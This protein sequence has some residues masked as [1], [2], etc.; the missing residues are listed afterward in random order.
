[1]GISKKLINSVL[2]VT[3]CA[4]SNALAQWTT[5]SGNVG[6]YYLG[7]NVGIGTSTP[8]LGY[9]LDVSGGD[10]IINGIT[11]GLGGVG[12]GSTAIGQN[13]LHSDGGIGNTALGFQ[14][15]Q[16]NTSGNYSTA[17]GYLAL[18]AS[19]GGYN[20]AFGA[21][22]LQ[23]NTTGVQNVS[24]G[25]SNLVSNT[26]GNG[27]TGIG[28]NALS[29]NTTGS[30]NSGLGDFAA[31]SNTTGTYNVG[32]GTYALKNNSITNGNTVVGSNA[33]FDFN[34][35]TDTVGYNTVIGYNSG[36]GLTDGNNNTIIGA[37]V[38]GLSSSLSNNI[39]IADGAGNRR[40][41][42][43]ANGNIGIGTTT[44]GSKLDVVGTIRTDVICD[45]TGSNCKTLAAGWPAS[46]T[47]TNIT[48]GIGLT[49]GSITTAGTI[50]LSNTG[51]VAG[52][53]GSATQSAVLAVDAQG[54]VTSASNVAIAG[55]GSGGTAGGDLSGT[56]PNPILV[57][58]GVI[59]GAYTKVNVDTKGRVTS[60]SNL[61]I[62]D[63]KSV[64]TGNWLTASGSCVSGQQLTYSAVSDNLS[65]QAYALTATQVTDA[66]GYVPSSGGTNVS[67]VAS[68]TSPTTVTASND[69]LT[70]NANAG[71]FTVTLPAASGN[72]GKNF[73]FKKIDSSANTVT[74]AAASG[75]TIDGNPSKIM[76][77]QND[78]LKIVSDGTNWLDI[79]Q[80]KNRPTN[81]VR[82]SSGSGTYTP[83]SGVLY[84]KVRMAGGGGGGGGSGTGSTYGSNGTSSTFGST[85][86]VANAGSG[87]AAPAGNGGSG[88][89]TTISSGA[90][91]SGFTGGNG[92]PSGYTADTSGGSGAASFFGGAGGG[93]YRG[94]AGLSAA[95]GT[96]SG[97][98]GGGGSPSVASSSG[99]GA[100]GY[101][102]AQIN[103]LAASYTYSVG[104]GGGGGTAGTSGYAGGSGGSGVIIVEE[105]Y[106]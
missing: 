78:I 51:V 44:P 17:S 92:S 50:G 15:L 84:I 38:T 94:T 34:R 64:G 16:L 60:G 11:V 81:I 49:G 80:K 18:T 90:I 66:L 24:V 83:S 31:Q 77:V 23:N 47:V 93:G 61:T 55:A 70:L 74:I 98:G 40:I 99:G 89:S 73:T 52:T 30:Y 22:A 59:A 14:A 63:V 35:T 86:L 2:L 43:D 1:M 105:Y 88:G 100:G 41:N 68:I 46:G 96:G 32:I 26:T 76:I 101:L 103:S 21:S 65:C 79:T 3:I 58:T 8:T 28:H 87:G 71:S 91:G 39:I 57:T 95:A 4:S 7:V 54:R 37:R 62:S 36:L 27:N 102:D 12:G 45:R 82:F 13:A 33:L 85:L 48:A 19:N 25:S 10:A 56:Y 9:K 72:T 67:N 104:S 42:V 6:I 29:T 75:Q 20:S 5:G 106:Q 53:Y 69:I 97:G